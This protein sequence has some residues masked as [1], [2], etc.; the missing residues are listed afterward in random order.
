MSPP[1]TRAGSAAVPLLL[2]PAAALRR[3]VAET[4]PRYLLGVPGGLVAY[5]LAMRIA[6]GDNRPE[7]FIISGLMVFLATWSDGTRRF[8]AGTLPFFL[9]GIVY[10]LTHITEP[11]FRHLH[12]H[13]SEPYLF[14]RTFFGIQTPEGTLTPNEFF[15]RHHWPVVDFFTG[16]AYI[17]F[18]YWAIGFGMYL[19]LFRRD[20]AGRRLLARFAWTF[21]LMNVVGF[22]TYYVYPAAPPWYVAAHG[23]GP[24]DFSVRSS[25]A[26]A[27]RFDAITGIPYFSEFYGRS[28]DVFGAIPSLHVTYPLLTFLYGRELRKRWLDVASFGLFLLVSFAAVYLDHHYVLDVMLGVLYA[29]VAWRVDLALQWWW[30]RRA[31]G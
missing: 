12:I 8:L 19:A 29:V 7:Q 2:R 11:L 3:R 28:A 10:D 21:L 24:P 31:T 9:F 23:L 6:T 27:T 30:R 5:L 17:I 4:P 18:V 13:I 22:A 14:D 15:A 26:G 16:L 25:P 20:E 1:S